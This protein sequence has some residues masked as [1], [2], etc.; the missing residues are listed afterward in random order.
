MVFSLTMRRALNTSTPFPFSPFCKQYRTVVP[1]PLVSPSTQFRVR[2]CSVSVTVL[3]RLQD[4]ASFMWHTFIGSKYTSCL[5]PSMT[6]CLHKSS[7]FALVNPRICSEFTLM[8]KKP[9]SKLLPQLP[10][11]VISKESP[12]NVFNKI[13]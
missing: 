6:A 1:S 4:S 3:P 13:H 9:G 7:N 2:W 5:H 11:E 8:A 10:R 12:I